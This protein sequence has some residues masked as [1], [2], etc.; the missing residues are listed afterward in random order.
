MLIEPAA[1]PAGPE[2]S[3]LR[4]L[5]EPVGADWLA[6]IRLSP[7]LRDALND[8]HSL[9][10]GES[11]LTPEGCWLGKHWLRFFA[12]RSEDSVLSR[13]QA[14]ETLQSRLQ[15]LERETAELQQEQ[16]A[17]ADTLRSEE[18]QRN[19]FQ[20]L[21]SRQLQERGARQSQLAKLQAQLTQTQLQ[22]TRIREELSE[23]DDQSRLDAETLAECRIQHQEDLEALQASREAEGMALRERESL[24]GQVLQLRQT[25]QDVRAEN[26][27]LALDHQAC[28]TREKALRQNLQRTDQHLSQLRQQLLHLQ[29]EL[30]GQHEPLAELAL[31]QE[32][33]MAEREG[34]EER[35]QRAESALQEASRIYREM[36]QYRHQLHAGIEPLRQELEARRLHWQN[37]AS[38]QEYLLEQIRE[39]G[40]DKEEIIAGLP[41]DMEEVVW[42]T[43]LEQLATRISRLGA[44]NLA[45]IEEYQ[46]QSERKGFLDTQS[47]DLEEAVEK[48]EN[49]IRHIDRETRTLFMDTYNQVNA[50]LQHLFPKVFGGGEATLNLVGD[51]SLNSG[52]T[53]MARPPG[54]KNSTIHL[55]SGGEK[56]LT[57]LSLV[58]AIFQLNPAPFCLLDEVDAP[59]DDANVGRFCR[60]VEE[61]AQTV[62]FIYITHN[63]IA[64]TM[65]QQLMGVTMHEPGVSRLVAVDV[66]QAAAMAAA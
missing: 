22:A 30:S 18:E 11:L 9:R 13:Q 54:K 26:H 46:Q 15:S 55:L 34:A 16:S 52:V 8:R 4:Q 12:A 39:L 40:V 62:Q 31:Q 7:S 41:A 33:L 50:G 28:Q 14:I 21:L 53:I 43:R 59:L 19:Q 24:R 48:L 25:L 27:R 10:A 65:A 49:A 58:F 42:Q 20:K 57:A 44:I 1:L 60:L 17:V 45:A 64:M 6:G 56:A 32:E 35:V 3:L 51:D 61:M 66:E 23:L 38:R 29:D 36:E 37:V 5:A 47:R 63:K 2:S